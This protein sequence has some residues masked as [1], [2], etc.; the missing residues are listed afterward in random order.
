M[1]LHLFKAAFL[2]LI[3]NVMFSLCAVEGL[4]PKTAA[5]SYIFLLFDSISPVLF[6]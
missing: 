2:K 5:C 4:D 6:I 1:V 3:R